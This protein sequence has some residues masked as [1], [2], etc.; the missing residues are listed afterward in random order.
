MKALIEHARAGT[1]KELAARAGI[2]Q[3]TLSNLER[4]GGRY[5]KET[6]QTIAEKAGFSLDGLNKL[7]AQ[8]GVAWAKPAPASP[9]M[10]LHD[11]P[12]SGERPS[13]E[14]L[15]RLRNLTERD[16]EEMILA[17]MREKAVP[18]FEALVVYWKSRWGEK[19]RR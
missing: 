9:A 19:P 11:Q 10:T 3:P 1:A 7:A 6:L 8:H 14:M 13:D 17:A 15:R 2:S 12:D 5:P 16:A 18:E 4:D